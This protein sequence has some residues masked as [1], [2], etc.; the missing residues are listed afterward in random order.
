M[1]LASSKVIYISSNFVCYTPCNKPPN[2]Q[3]GCDSLGGGGCFWLLEEEW[4]V[5]FAQHTGSSAL[6][7]RKPC[8]KKEHLREMHSILFQ[9]AWHQQPKTGASL[10]RGMWPLFLPSIGCGMTLLT[11][12]HCSFSGVI[13]GCTEQISRSISA[14]LCLISEMIVPWGRVMVVAMWLERLV[15][16]LELWTPQGHT[17]WRG[18]RWF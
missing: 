18:L 7:K 11:C 16:R 8:E 3:C 12:F 5:D 4:S 9:L 14:V 13:W 15:L 1:G 10:L 17:A 2:P 6:A